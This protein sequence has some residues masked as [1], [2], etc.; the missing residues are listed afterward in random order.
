MKP[1]VNN[2]G[3]LG[4]FEPPLPPPPPTLCDIFGL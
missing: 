4:H 2:L 3:V 1:E